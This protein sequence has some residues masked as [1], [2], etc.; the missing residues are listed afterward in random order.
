MR[1]PGMAELEAALEQFCDEVLHDVTIPTPEGPRRQVHWRYRGRQ[2]RA[3]VLL[4]QGRDEFTPN[5]FARWRV[6]GQHF[7]QLPSRPIFEFREG[8]TAWRLAPNFGL[9]RWSLVTAGRRGA[10]GFRDDD[11]APG[12]LAGR[13]VRPRPGPPSLGAGAAA[14]PGPP[15][16]EETR[17]AVA[18][19]ARGQAG[20]DEGDVASPWH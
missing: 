8:P 5:R 13:P 2:F 17:R 15:A 14:V 10:G 4:H 20:L 3:S 11:P 9:W 16:P 7:D 19:I 6:Q 18:L 1:D 12:D